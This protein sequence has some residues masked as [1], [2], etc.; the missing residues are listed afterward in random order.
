MGTP[1]YSFPINIRT[2]APQSSQIK[3]KK[4]RKEG[5]EEGKE[6]EGKKRGGEEGRQQNPVLVK[7]QSTRI[8]KISHDFSQ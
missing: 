8:Q 1:L 3:K 7:H 2:S 6:G 5:R 4:K